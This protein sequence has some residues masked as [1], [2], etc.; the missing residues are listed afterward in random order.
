MV[1]ARARLPLHSFQEHFDGEFQNSQQ[2]AETG[3]ES[4]GPDLELCSGVDTETGGSLSG[5]PCDWTAAAR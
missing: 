3:E 2:R 1:P 4:C 5:L